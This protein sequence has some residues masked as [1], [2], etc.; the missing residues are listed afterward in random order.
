MSKTTSSDC[1]L[2]K[3]KN[4]TVVWGNKFFDLN[5]FKKLNNINFT[6]SCEQFHSSIMLESVCD[7]P[8]PKCDAI[9]TDK[10]KY[11]LAI[12][13]ADCVPVMVKHKN[14]VFALHAGWRGLCQ[15]ILFN[16]NKF[17][18]DDTSLAFIGPH[19]SC[20]SYE[21]GEEVIFEV[22]NK[23]SDLV[24]MKH[25]FIQPHGSKFLLDLKTLTQI[26]L[27]E[28]GFKK[29]NIISEDINTLTN[30]QWNSYRREK[31]NAGRNISLIYRH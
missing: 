7:S 24:G 1:I 2:I 13:T 31:N 18:I 30:N 20:D 22:L 26:Q 6:G 27:L 15:K 5:K 17:K 21:V 28:V 29:E 10:K 11:A 3:E 14:R 8:P 16:L 12:K 19:I 23:N 4:F 25:S 9:Y